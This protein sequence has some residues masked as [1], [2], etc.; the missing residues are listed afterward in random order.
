MEPTI[1]SVILSMDF[2]LHETCL[3]GTFESLK[4]MV[5]SGKF[6]IDCES[7]TGVTPMGIVAV[8]LYVYRPQDVDS[9]S[10]RE[11]E[12]KIIFL[13]QNGANPLKKWCGGTI[14]DLIFQ[15]GNQSMIHL[16]FKYFE[17]VDTPLNSF[18][19]T[20]LISAIRR[21]YYKT[22]EILLGMKADVNKGCFVKETP[23]HHAASSGRADLFHL[24]IKH[25]ASMELRSDLG[26]T[27]LHSA[28]Y[29]AEDEKIIKKYIECDHNLNATDNE[30]CTPL[31][32]LFIK[33]P[34]TSAVSEELV[35]VFLDR[36]ADLNIKDCRGLTP[37]SWCIK[38]KNAPVAL[39]FL[40]N[41]ANLDISEEEAVPVLK[42]LRGILLEDTPLGQTVLKY[43]ALEI[44]KGTKINRALEEYLSQQEGVTQYL[45]KCYREIEK[46]RKRKIR[47]TSVNYWRLLTKSVAELAR[48]ANNPSIIGAMRKYRVGTY[49][50]Y[51][52]EIAYK[53][54]KAKRRQKLMAVSSDM[55]NR[56]WEGKM[57]SLFVKMVTDHLSISDM[58]NVK[59]ARQ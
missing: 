5:K 8:R 18:G 55:F 53:F 19:H 27:P 2:P 43:I 50:I 54:A 21:G 59:T 25:G 13:L 10:V 16:M 29:H 49:P 15:G 38:K 35:E 58:E 23:L 32:K 37:L 4:K 26:E 42:Y 20:A 52:R 22:A 33:F 40:R 11:Y 48:Y 56:Y 14:A 12:R 47:N 57:P 31:H 51:G 1:L 44:S 17:D 46:L 34:E 36:G 28:C 7:P 3:H 39:L 41:G 6:F 30:G 45:T 9:R 24:L